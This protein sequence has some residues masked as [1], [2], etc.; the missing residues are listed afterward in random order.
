MNDAEHFVKDYFREDGWE[1]VKW[2]NPNRNGLIIWC[3][4][5]VTNVVLIEDLDGYDPI[6]ITCTS[7]NRAEKTFQENVGESRST[8]NWELQAEYD[9]IWGENN[10]PQWEC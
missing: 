8:P 2:A 6:E 3:R 10:P 7:A 1:V 5:G 4:K 9:A